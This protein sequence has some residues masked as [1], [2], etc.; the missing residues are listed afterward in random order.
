MA[1]YFAPVIFSKFLSTS[2]A[3]AANM[4]VTLVNFFSTFIALYLVDR[5]GRRILLVS[6][7]AGMGIF[8]GL[9]A[10]LTTPYFDYETNKT[11]GISLIIFTAIYVMNFAY[12]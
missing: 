5:A 3:I 8:T 12:S 7:G 10:I 2:G 6:G 9:F 4:A 11:I 1:R